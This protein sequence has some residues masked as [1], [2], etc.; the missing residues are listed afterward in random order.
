MFHVKHSGGLENVSRET[1]SKLE[2]YAELLTKWNKKINL[3]SPKTLGE[4]WDRHILDSYQL[5][6]IIPP[7]TPTMADLG[8][9][10]GLPGL[11]IA[12]ARPTMEITLVERDERK[13]AFLTQA[14]IT[15]GLPK[16]R[17]SNQSIETIQTRYHLVSARALA[18]LDELLA[19]AAPILWEDAFCLF[20]KGENFAIEIEEA[21]KRWDFTY[22]AIPSKTHD[23]AY[24]ISISKL[25]PRI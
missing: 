6:E 1:F 11:V 23:S 8:S 15:L 18:S 21:K 22:Q 5:V 2:Q 16:V 17:V 13:C 9:G 10:G 3:V 25:K 14:A 20:P 24:I 7:E 19:L 12:I 4:L